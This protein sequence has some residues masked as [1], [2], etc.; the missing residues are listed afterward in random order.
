MDINRQIYY[1]NIY[2]SKRQPIRNKN[3]L[4]KDVHAGCDIQGQVI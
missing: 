4:G 1:K 3:E 2:Y